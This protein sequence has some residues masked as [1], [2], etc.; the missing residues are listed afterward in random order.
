MVPIVKTWLQE[1][2]RIGADAGP[3]LSEEKRKKGDGMDKAIPSN[4]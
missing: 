4:Q 3:P 2:P 1:R